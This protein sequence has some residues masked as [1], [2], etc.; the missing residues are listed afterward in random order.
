LERLKELYNL[1][2]SDI[3]ES[4]EEDQEEEWRK[5]SGTEKENLKEEVGKEAKQM[6]REFFRS[7]KH[8]KK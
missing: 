7:K 8:R 4:F 5:L 6:M 2:L 3:F 1:F